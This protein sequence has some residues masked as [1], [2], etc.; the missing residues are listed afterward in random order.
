MTLVGALPLLPPE[1]LETD[2]CCC[3]CL[4]FLLPLLADFFLPLD[5]AFFAGC[6]IWDAAAEAEAA[7]GAAI[8]AATGATG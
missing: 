8:A 6:L 3:C 5:E 7:A 1:A 2:A 4:F